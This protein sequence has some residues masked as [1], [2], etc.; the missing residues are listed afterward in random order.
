MNR[1]LSCGLLALVALAGPAFA[2]DPHGD[3]HARPKLK[4]ELAPQPGWKQ[5][6]PSSG[7]RAAQFKLPGKEGGKDLELVVYHFGAGRGGTVDDNVTRWLAQVKRPADAPA[8]RREAWAQNGLAIHTVEADGTYVAE[9]RPGGGE[10]HSDAGSRLLG[11]VVEGAD[12]PYFVKLVG[13]RADVERWTESYRAF[14]ESLDG[15][16]QLGVRFVAPDPSW[17]LSPPS[18]GMRAAEFH[19]PPAGQ[20]GE[21]PTV[22][23]YHFGKGQGGSVDA[24]FQRWAA[25]FEAEG[26][27]VRGER[28]AGGLICHTLALQGTYAAETRPG[29]G[30]R[31]R[32]EGWALRAAVIEGADGPY[33]VK[34]IGPTSAV[35]AQEKAFEAFLDKGVVVAKR[36]F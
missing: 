5:E 26:Q 27:P 36:F 18:S 1:S 35:K 14:L 34:L 16:R 30:Q 21:G 3:P 29:S 6:A 2:Q 32:K 12:G 13:P 25:Q 7:M 28:K 11:A 15:G 8:P 24:N 9:M 19:L 23:V 4:V 31:V 10:R 20:Q 22:V 17:Q 33:F